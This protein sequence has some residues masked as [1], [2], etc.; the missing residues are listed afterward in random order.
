MDLKAI[1]EMSVRSIGFVVAGL[2]A[3]VVALTAH[4]VG[5]HFVFWSPTEEIV[6]VSGDI[7]L[8]GTLIK[9][10][11]AGVF[12]AVVI[13]HGSGPETRGDPWNRVT[14][15]ALARGGFAVLI[16]D[17]RGTGASGGNFDAA[18]YRDFVVDA[19]AAVRY[20]ASR[21]DI[22]SDRIGLFGISESGWLTPEIAAVSHGVAFIV[23]RVGPPLSWI[24]T[25]LWEARNEFLSE[26]A[27]EADLDMLLALTRRKWDYLRAAAADPALAV[28]LEREALEAAFRE[29]RAM[30]AL[31]EYCEGGGDHD[32]FPLRFPLEHLGREVD[33]GAFSHLR[34]INRDSSFSVLA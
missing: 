26:G 6:F 27:A 18:L 11:G 1:W 16:Y 24:E 2:V 30:A 4:N 29:V 20:L 28:G 10:A 14:A 32:R 22:D 17:K 19:I 21:E 8:A 7:R 13:L 33:V 12:S 9:P 23:N 15:K 31:V 25:V 34:E 5:R 3:L